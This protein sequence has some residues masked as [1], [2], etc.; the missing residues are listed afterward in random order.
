MTF[1]ALKVTNADFYG[2][3]LIL[4]WRLKKHEPLGETIVSRVTWRVFLWYLVLR[5]FTRHSLCGDTFAA[6][7]E[8][9]AFWTY[10]AW[11]ALAVGISIASVH[12]RCKYEHGIAV[13]VE[14]LLEKFGETTDALLL[15]IQ[16]D[17]ALDS[18]AKYLRRS[19]RCRGPSG[20]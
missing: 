5:L 20:E 17:D 19:K 18:L 12:R 3:L 15:A 2:R 16:K 4:E 10:P 11:F 14:R 1:S 7:L 8:T 6:W 9:E 13:Q